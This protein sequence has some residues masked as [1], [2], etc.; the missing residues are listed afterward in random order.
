[1]KKTSLTELHDLIGKSGV[2]SGDTV[3][4]HADLRRFG[5]IENN[6][7][8]LV[9]MLLS[10]VGDT[11]TI[12]TPSFTFS[13]PD[14]FDLKNSVSTTGSLTRLFSS[15]PDVVRVPDGMTSYYLIG[16]N[17]NRFISNWT[18]TSY[19]EGSIPDQICSASGKV[20]QL[21]TDV[22]SHIHYLEEK[23]GVPY[24]KI[25]RFEGLIVDGKDKYPSYTDFY[26][27]VK[28]VEKIIPDPIRV[29]FYAKIDE[30][31]STK[32]IVRSF[33]VD[34]FLEFSIPKLLENPSILVQTY[35]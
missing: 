3:I 17:A 7:R 33:D 13:F 18:N 8:D 9:A 2:G 35:D 15:H 6:A 5:L 24:R 26:A 12:I 27:R 14:I 32:S 23:V 31:M 11:G 16:H 25:L 34:H 4:V 21:G 19:G 28:K 10:I 22:L 29:S 20:L 1:M 30:S